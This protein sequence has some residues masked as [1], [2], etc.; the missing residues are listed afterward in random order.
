MQEL[1]ASTTVCGILSG[2]SGIVKL[3]IPG[4]LWIPAQVG[5]ERC[6]WSL[7]VLRFGSRYHLGIPGTKTKHANSLKA[8]RRPHHPER[9]RD[10]IEPVDL[11][12]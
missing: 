12:D 7:F 1:G 5:F 10:H 3:D 8:Q 11:G 4:S 6:F 9:C 2:A